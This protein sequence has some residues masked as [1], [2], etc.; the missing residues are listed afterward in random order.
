ML[1]AGPRWR[2]P[3]RTRISTLYTIQEE[4]QYGDRRGKQWPVF[5]NVGKMIKYVK[6]NIWRQKVVFM[7]SWRISLITTLPECRFVG[8][9][10]TLLLLV[11]YSGITITEESWTR[12]YPEHCSILPPVWR[13]FRHHII[14]TVVTRH[15]TESRFPQYREHSP[16]DPPFWAPLQGAGR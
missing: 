8:I 2:L 6:I 9:T 1:G 3:R 15:M 10:I 11:P 13:H 16:P 4:A 5:V 12:H 14:G 7:E